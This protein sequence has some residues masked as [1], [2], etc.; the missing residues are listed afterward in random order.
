MIGE[1][2]EI[3]AGNL[4]FQL[5]LLAVVVAILKAVVF[6]FVP[7]SSVPVCLM[8]FSTCLI[9]GLWNKIAL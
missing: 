4:E 3:G 1:Q 8:K 7:L 6:G 5:Q 2:D 9:T